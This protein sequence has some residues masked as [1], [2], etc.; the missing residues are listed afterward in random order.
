MKLFRN[1]AAS[2]GI[3]L[4]LLAVAVPT[5]VMAQPG[6]IPPRSFSPRM[7][8]DQ[9]THYLRFSVS[10]NSCVQAGTATAQTCSVKVGAVPYNAFLL[11]AYQQIITSFTVN[12]TTTTGTMALGTAVGSGNIVA[13]QSVTGAAGGATVLTI[14]AANV[15]ITVTGNNIAPTGA[16]GGFDIYATLAIGAASGTLSVTAGQAIYVL[17]YIAPNDGSCINVP[18]GSSSPAC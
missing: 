11:R 12:G 10:F 1:I 14:V 7:F 16:L 4:S 8:S 17:E 9:Q 15:G 2:A 6:P 5:I 3:A 13:A 18:L